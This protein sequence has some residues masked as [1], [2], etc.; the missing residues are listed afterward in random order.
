M[1]P[2]FINTYGN[3]HSRTHQYGWESEKG[4]ELARER[5]AKIISA[6][7]KEV[8]FTSGATESNNIAIKGAARFYASKKKHIITTQTEHKC[9]LDSCRYLEANEGFRVTYLPVGTGGRISLQELKEAIRPDTVMV[10]VMSVNNEI[11]TIQPLEEI[12]RICRENKV[13]FHTDAAQAVGKIPMNVESMNIDLMSISGHKIYGPKGVGALYVRRRPRVRIDP[14]QSGGGQERGIRSGTVPTPLV[15]G[16]GAAC[17]ISLQEMDYDHEWVTKLSNRLLERVQAEIPHVIRNGDPAHSY[18]GCLNLSFAYIEGES[19]LMALKDVALSSGSACTSASLEPSYVLR[20]IGADEDLAHSSIRFGI[21]RFTTE[22][23]IDYTANRC[24]QHA[25]KLRD[26]SPLWEMVQEGVDIKP[27]PMSSS[28]SSSSSFFFSSF[29]LLSSAGAAAAAPGAAA[30][31]AGAPDPTP[32]PTLDTSVLRS[33]F[34]TALANNPGQKGSTSTC[35]AFNKAWILSA[36]MG[37]L[38]SWR[39]SAENT[40]ATFEYG[41]KSDNN[42]K[43]SK[44][45]ASVNQDSRKMAGATSGND[46]SATFMD[47]LSQLFSECDTEKSGR[48]GRNNFKD[49]CLKIGLSEQDAFETFD[50]LDMD[51]DG[52]ITLDEFCAGFQQYK[53]SSMQDPNVA[54]PSDSASSDFRSINT[55]SESLT[56]QVSSGQTLKKPSRLALPTRSRSSTKLSSGHISPVGAISIGTSNDDGIVMSNEIGS[57]NSSMLNPGLTAQDS[58]DVIESTNYNEKVMSMHELLECVQSLQDENQRLANTLLREKR[59]RDHYLSRLGEEMDQRVEEVEARVGKRAREEIESERRRLREMMKSELEGLQQHFQTLE[60]V[61]QWISSSGSTSKDVDGEKIEKVKS[62]LEDS[63]VE[64]RHLRMSLLDTQTNVAMMKNEIDQLKEQYGEKCHEF[65]SERERIYETLNECDHIKLQLSLVKDSNRKLQDTSDAITT[66][67]ADSVETIANKSLP[68]LVDG[69]HCSTPYTSMPTNQPTP[70]IQAPKNAR[71]LGSNYDYRRGSVLSDYLQ[72]VQSMSHNNSD[73]ESLNSQ[74]SSTRNIG[75]DYDDPDEYNSQRS[76]PPHSSA[77]S[78]TKKHHNTR[79]RTV[80]NHSSFYNNQWRRND[81]S[82]ADSDYSDPSSGVANTAPTSDIGSEHRKTRK[83]KSQKS[84][85]K[86][87]DNG[88]MSIETNGLASTNK[89]LTPSFYNDSAIYDV[90]PNV[91]S[92]DG[93]SCSTYDII[94][95][96]DSY[97]G[98]SSFVARFMEGGF[99]TGLISN[100]GIDFKTKTLKIDGL[101]VTI[102]LWDT[103]GQ[104]RFRSI[105]ASYFRKADGIIL[106]YDV[107]EKRSYINVR[108]WMSTIQDT[109]TEGVPVLLVGNKIDLRTK[110]NMA[111]CVPPLEGERLAREYDI[112]FLETSVKNGTGL[113]PAVSKLVRLMMSKNESHSENDDTIKL[114][115]K[116]RNF[117]CMPQK[118]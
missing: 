54:E 105:T 34:S 2:Y 62:K 72:D 25:S 73:L 16:L 21:G 48:L 110:E 93:V 9:V 35:A 36:V 69:P 80:R 101:N 109:S 47:H 91:E 116:T 59:E 49:L 60:K 45:C 115:A 75:C 39:I 117:A 84:A 8:V 106:M 41:N 71:T 90:D 12:G 103:A 79:N 5:V 112:V 19:L 57:Q 113:M 64:N 55:N 22:Q 85:S 63:L 31:A 68:T 111:S 14:I 52:S 81:G 86:Q 17:E 99:V 4:V 92:P 44:S 118:C 97:V 15:V 98:K 102:N 3:P 20:A 67:M 114:N 6:D 50:R 7:P 30:A 28:S 76:A 95:V 104:E 83:S 40:Q 87:I 74:I 88:L 32:D 46:S 42:K 61:N 29:F 108:N 37:L 43:T 53:S 56:S 82:P 10:S 65:T 70:S 96:G 58:C 51:R 89:S 23:E 24:I 66:Y 13:L 94:L 78:K 100:C 77:S 38:S 11:G 18:P 107:T 33:T 1:I 26:M 27:N